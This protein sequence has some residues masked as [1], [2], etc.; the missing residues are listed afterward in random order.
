MYDVYIVLVI[1][2]LT[3]ASA[4]IDFV[5]HHLT[6][7]LHFTY[8]YSVLG[9]FPLHLHTQGRSGYPCDGAAPCWRAV[10]IEHA[11]LT[12]AHVHVGSRRRLLYYVVRQVS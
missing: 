10:V 6:L 7:S 9:I 12:T 11:H 1:H 2:V 3:T 8:I 4:T 5:S